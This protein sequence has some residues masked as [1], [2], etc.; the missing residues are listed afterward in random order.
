M[1]NSVEV[2]KLYNKKITYMP[3]DK[4]RF[5]AREISLYHKE[6]GVFDL[7]DFMTSI[8]NTETYEVLSYI[9]MLNLNE[10]YTLQEIDDYI[11]VIKE[12]NI[13][14]Q[15]KRLKDKMKNI[16]DPVEQSKIAEEIK[17]LK[18]DISG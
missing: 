7:A 15:I 14:Y 11:N 18:I 8:S 6:N 5:L 10:D 16:S 17:K 12:Y 3:N 4:F 9:L 2:I 13:N 1:L